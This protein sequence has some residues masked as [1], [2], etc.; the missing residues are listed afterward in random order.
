MGFLGEFKKKLNSLRQKGAFHIFIGSFITKFVAFFGSIFIVR[1]L[2]KSDYGIL[3]YV[4]NFFNYAYVLAG[5]GLT[6]ALLRYVILAEKK[7][8]KFAYYRYVIKYGSIF[9]IALF[10]AACI[11]GFFY[12][13]PEEFALAKWFLPILLISLPFR[14][15]CDSQNSLQRAM[16]D[17]KRFAYWACLISVSVVLGKLA[18]SLLFGLEGAIVSWVLVYGVLALALGV[19]VHKTFFRDVTPGTLTRENKRV[20]NRYSIQ[21][22]IT[23]SIWAAWRGHGLRLFRSRKKRLRNVPALP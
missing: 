22:M 1:V 16:F 6:N 14:Y 7:E 12:P 18:A 5:M 23:N 4:E 11:F 20:T 8:G 15:L 9:N 13:H 17:N 2:S 21:Y 10:V 19:Y 3:S